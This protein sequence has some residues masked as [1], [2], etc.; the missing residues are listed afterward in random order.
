MEW[1]LLGFFNRH[2]ILLVGVACEKNQALGALVADID[3]RD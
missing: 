1:A 3:G 2:P